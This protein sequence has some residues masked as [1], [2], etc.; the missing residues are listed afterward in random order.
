MCYRAAQLR[1]RTNRADL[2]L[3]ELGLRA[4]AATTCLGKC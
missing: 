1:K 4:E 3:E 2:E